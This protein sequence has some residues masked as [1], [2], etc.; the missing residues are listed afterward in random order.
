M[1]VAGVMQR[2]CVP[3]GWLREDHAVFADIIGRS[4]NATFWDWSGGSTLIFWQWSKDFRLRA[5][6]GVPVFISKKLLQYKKL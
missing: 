5:R 4:A 6:D 1:D 3:I 2:A